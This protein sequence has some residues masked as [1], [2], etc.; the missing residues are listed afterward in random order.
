MRALAVVE[1]GD[2]VGRFDALE[3]IGT[4]SYWEG[5][6]E[7]VVRLA[8]ERLAIAERIGR[9]TSSAGVLLELNDVQNARLETDGLACPLRWRSSWPRRA[10]ARR[11]RGWILRAAGR[12][13][14]IDGRLAD[15]EAALDESPSDLDRELARP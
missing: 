10:G 12:Q 7:E 3:V 11:R 6:L 1:Q 4:V 8:N 5:D 15:A 14:A 13:A 2:D 9:P